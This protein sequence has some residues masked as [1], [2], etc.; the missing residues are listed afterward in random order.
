MNPNPECKLSIC[1]NYKDQK[2]DKPGCILLG[3]TS[4]VNDLDILLMQDEYGCP[5]SEAM[6]KRMNIQRDL[7]QPQD[8]P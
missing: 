8:E 1:P 6:E 4:S 3:L 2:P 7:D 5:F